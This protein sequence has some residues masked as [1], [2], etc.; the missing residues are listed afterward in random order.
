MLFIS[1]KESTF[2]YIPP[3]ESIKLF[4][5]ETKTCYNLLLLVSANFFSDI[6]FYYIKHSYLLLEF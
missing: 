1:I 3:S 4:S 6:S 5:M 2:K